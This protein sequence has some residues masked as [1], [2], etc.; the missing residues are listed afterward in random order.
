[1]TAVDAGE[2]VIV[3]RKAKASSA[4]PRALRKPRV[5]KLHPAEQYLADVRDGRIVTSKYVRMAVDRHFRDLEDGHERGLYF[6]RDAALHFIE[7][8][9]EFLQHTEGEWD[10]QPFVLHPSQAAK[11]WILY[12]WKRAGGY[13]RFSMA[14]DEEAR[15]QGKSTQASGFCLYELIA[16][17]EAGA[18]VYSAST[19]KKTA[20]LVWDTAALMVQRNPELHTIIE[21]RPGVANMHI[22][23][24]ASKFEA[25]ASEHDK[26]M[27]LRPSA[28]CIDELH[29]LPN[30]DLLDVLVSAMGKRKN[31]LGLLITNS[32]FDRNSCC[33][34]QRE[35]SIRV[36]EAA[37]GEDHSF[38]DDS[39]F[40]WIQC[41]DDEDDWEDESCWV[42]ANPMLECGVV[43]IENLRQQA[44]K[45]KNDPSSL[46]AFLR[47]RMSRWTEGDVIWMPMHLWDLCNGV[48][49]ME[50]M[51][52]RYCVG[53]LDLSTTTDM[54]ALGL[55]F[56]PSSTD[57]KW[58]V[59]VRYFLPKDAIL[60]RSKK[61]RVPYDVWAREGRIILTPGA[62]VDYSFIRAE[63]HRMAEMFE[64]KEICFDRWNSSDLVR[65]L[66][67]DGFTMVKWGQGMLDM[68]AP[69]KRMKELVVQQEIA[70]G[71]DPILRWNTRNVV[72]EID[73][74]GFEKPDKSKCREKI[75]GMQAS[76][77]ALGYGM[78]VAGPQYTSTFV[79]CL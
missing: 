5:K 4:R 57:A 41:I 48:V 12:G 78:R 77:M 11:W 39:W 53:G 9:E 3:E 59:L 10:G 67:A 69:T 14:F 47:F 62:V 73:A 71:A 65:D 30:S 1:M 17:G 18:Q 31:A 6:D 61:D 7:F 21:L 24:T 28:F 33:W 8:F 79:G 22:P 34:K 44:L 35:Y 58:R 43:N 23:G 64:L 76:L 42:K 13:R 29:M 36:L 51:R 49:S 40:A 46:N 37:F 38:R 45:A 20:R 50:D 70:H 25:L 74:A 2:E 54:T 16:F 52:G 66:E 68:N 55:M 27:G 26:L 63:V 15:G 60:Q 19:D 75:D 32:G 72:T 56:P